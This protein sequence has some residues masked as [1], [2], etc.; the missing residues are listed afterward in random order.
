LE[1]LTGLL[2]FTT[3]VVRP[4]RAFIRRL[5]AL[6]AVGSHQDHL[7]RLSIPD[8]Y[9]SGSV[10]W[11]LIVM[12]PWPR[13]TNHQSSLGCI[14]CM[15]LGAYFESKWF[16]M[17]WTARLD[18][19]CIAVKE[20][21]PV[22]ISAATLGRNWGGQVEF[23]VDNSAVVLNATLSSDCHLMHLIRLLVFFCNE[24]QI[25]VSSFT[26]SRHQDCSCRCIVQEL[27]VN[28]FHTGIWASSAGLKLLPAAS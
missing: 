28:I 6:Q 16:Q 9:I 21:I 13:G 19:L 7:V 5:Y 15:V 23:V 22:V 8:V 26:Y 4:G 2:Q 10:E 17:R 11:H 1:S 20:L 25:L 27:L 3:K 12:G 14:R 24:T 18:P